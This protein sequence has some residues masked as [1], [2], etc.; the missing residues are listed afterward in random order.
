MDPVIAA[1]QDPAIVAAI[2]P[3]ESIP[4]T[5]DS[6]S[7]W[8]TLVGT[9]GMVAFE[10]PPVAWRKVTS[11]WVETIMEGGRPELLVVLETGPTALAPEGKVGRVTVASEY[12]DEE[13][14]ELARLISEKLAAYW[15]QHAPDA[16][17]WPRI[18]LTPRF[19]KP[20]RVLAA[21]D[22]AMGF[23][24]RECPHGSEVGLGRY[25]EL[26]T[27]LLRMLAAMAFAAGVVLVAGTLAVVYMAG[28]DRDGVGGLLA[29][30]ELVF[31]GIWLWLLVTAVRRTLRRRR[32]RV[33]VEGLQVLPGT[34]PIPWRD[35]SGFDLGMVEV[36]V[37]LK[38][39]LVPRSDTAARTGV[40]EMVFEFALLRMP[41]L[42]RRYETGQLHW[43][44]SAQMVADRARER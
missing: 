33:G 6:P 37:R 35:I 30:L 15:W 1:E 31:A 27:S 5:P 43:L 11:L 28:Q 20:E 8:V 34:E 29:L 44:I 4:V 41:G 32:L 17:Q 7:D 16:S 39:M 38:L 42:A 18:D 2:G 10:A 13:T 36:G 26:R 9:D 3:Y 24:E 23:F 22:G 12:S 21:A 40:G 14:G 25:V 19:D